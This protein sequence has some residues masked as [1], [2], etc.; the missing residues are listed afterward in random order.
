MPSIDNS[1]LMN[2]TCLRIKDPKVTIPFYTEGLGFKLIKTFPF[3]TFTLY[4]LNYENESN[5]DLNWSAREGVLE[6]CH[7]HGVENDPDYKLNHGNGTEFR[8]FGHICVTVDNIEVVQE[9]LLA[10][11][12]KFQKKLSDGRQKNIAFALDPNGYWIELVENGIN[13]VEAKTDSANYRF[14]HSMI[15]VKDPK[16]SLDFYKN[17][18]GFKIISKKDFP[19]AKFTLYFLGYDHDPEF[20]EDSQQGNEQMKRSSLIE[21]THNWGT[22]SDPDFKGYHNGNSTENGAIQGY[23]HTCVS[24]KDPAKFCA[25][26]EQELGDKADWSLKWDQGNIKKIAFIRDPD[27]YSVEILGHD[28]FANQPN[29]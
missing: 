27:G 25:E 11:G 5:K 1:F 7:N 13:K 6:L 10:K 24:C 22:E 9:K 23:G 20:K 28:L 2:H 15:R 16:K 18:L 4:M 19:E 3:E 14:N 12:V 26:I 17:V 8:G 21:L 29:L